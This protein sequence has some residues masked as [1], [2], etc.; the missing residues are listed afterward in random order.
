MKTDFILQAIYSDIDQPAPER[1]SNT[2]PLT[3]GHASHTDVNTATDIEIPDHIRQES[4]IS[5]V[6][7]IFPDL[8]DGFV[9]KCLEHFGMSSERVISCVL[10][11][12]LPEGLRS[13]DRSLP[14][15]PE[16]VVDKMFLQTGIERLNVFDGD[17]FDIMTR[18]DVD[19]T[20]VH[21]GKRKEKYKDLKDLLNDKTDVK[22]VVDI[23]SK[24][25]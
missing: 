14:I 17:E 21:K 25:K 8:G 9:L 15:I 12:S 4:L 10:E 23:Y 3:N 7:D 5:E 13:L 24:Y 20:K 1:V 22:K 19:L 18:D 11:D 6:K 16:D 2:E